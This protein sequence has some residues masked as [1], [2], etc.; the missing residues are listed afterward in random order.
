MN[1][2]LDKIIVVDVETS[3]VDTSKHG[4]LSIGAVKLTKPEAS[5]YTECQLDLDREYDEGALKINGF[6][7]EDCHNQ[8]RITEL[9]AV[10]DFYKWAEKFRVGGETLIFAGQNPDFDAGF[11]RRKKNSWPF[12]RRYLDLHSVAFATFCKSL[13][14]KEICLALGLPPEP[15]PHNALFG[16]KSEAECFKKLFAYDEQ[17]ISKGKV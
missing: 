6:T 4:L 10:T 16:A 8:N 9:Q 11:L 7:P 17:T 1:H 2:D 14:H 15:E 12:R 13:C 5:F 3:G